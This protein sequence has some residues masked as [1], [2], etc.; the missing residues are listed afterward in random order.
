MRGL[1]KLAAAFIVFG[2]GAAA[3]AA[4]LQVDFQASTN[5]TQQTPE[6]WTS[7]HGSTSDT[8]AKQ[9]VVGALTAQ[10]SGQAGFFDRGDT[11]ISNSFAYERLY[12]D[13]VYRNG[14][15]SGSINFSVSGLQSNTPYYVRLYSYDDD[16]ALP[17]K[18]LTT[19]FS[20]D[21]ALQTSGSSGT[22]TYT[23]NQDPTTEHQYSV[24]LEFTTS[25]TGVLGIVAS[26]QNGNNLRV[27]GFEIVS[28]VPEPASLS[29]LGLAGLAALRRRRAR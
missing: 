12:R 17:A 14:P 13:F 27:N 18:T 2:I 1:K 16:N 11:A 9:V 24:L 19:V 6:V 29:L 15:S 25:P 7:L 10:V 3:Q 23:T 21:T 22:V 20:A 28:V 4:I 26:E 5:Q 8:N